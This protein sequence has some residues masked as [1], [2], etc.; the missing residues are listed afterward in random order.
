MMEGMQEA[1]KALA[2]AETAQ[3]NMLNQLADR[4]RE[5]VKLRDTL[6]GMEVRAS[7]AERQVVKLHS[8]EKERNTYRLV[9]AF[10]V[11]S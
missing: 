5:I 8:A 2:M 3:K 10:V 4:D 6:E 9:M 11:I 7:K 1:R